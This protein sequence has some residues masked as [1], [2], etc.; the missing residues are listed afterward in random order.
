MNEVDKKDRQPGKKRESA[1]RR[2]ATTVTEVNQ[3]T[4]TVITSMRRP[5]VSI[6]DQW[7]HEEINNVKNFKPLRKFLVD[8]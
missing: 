5:N 7:D 2:E 8:T 3:P 4:K 1:E 6:I